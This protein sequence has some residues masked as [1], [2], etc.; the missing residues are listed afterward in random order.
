MVADVAYRT[1][2]DLAK[3]KGPFPLF[4]PTQYYADTVPH[5]A[6][7]IEK[8]GIRNALLT[9]IAPTGTISLYAGN[10]SSGIEPIFATAYNRKVLQ[11]DGSHTT[12][13]V[14]DY[15][16]AEYR[17]RSNSNDL[18]DWFVTAQDLPPSAHVKMQAAAQKWVDSAISKTVNVPA[19]ISFDDF[20]SVYMLAYDLGCKGCT[21]YRPNAVTGS[22]LTVSDDATGADDAA[23]ACVYDPETGERSCAG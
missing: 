3:E 7:E 19:D 16:V 11:P 9:S 15:A 12:E 18:P 14:V 17:K 4:D 20:K 22:V 5:L 23:Q 8:H 6:L 13:E 21:T 10:V 2:I 1:S